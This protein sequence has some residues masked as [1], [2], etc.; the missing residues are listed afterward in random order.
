MSLD[1]QERA[2]AEADAV[3]APSRTCAESL[4]GPA[5]EGRLHTT[6]LRIEDT[7]E[8][9]EAAA[10]RE[11]SEAKTLLYVG[12]FADVQGTQEFFQM[13]QNAL[14]LGPSLPVAVAGGVPDNLNADR[15]WQ[16]DC[17][18]DIA[19]RLRFVGWCTREVLS[20]HLRSARVLV[21]PGWTETFGLTVLEG[22]LHGVPVVASSCSG[23]SELDRSRVH[24]APCV[25]S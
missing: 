25:G 2:I 5:V 1:G 11:M 19:E 10:Q 4:K 8:A 20:L 23:S 16:A 17:P 24:G 13:A 22:M 7:P 9:R 6:T 3:F 12:R 15:R 18:P 14:Q 21:V